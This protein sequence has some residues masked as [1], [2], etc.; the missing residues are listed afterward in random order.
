VQSL[1]GGKAPFGGPLVAGQISQAPELEARGLPGGHGN[2]DFGLHAALGV[3]YR[4]S[5]NFSLGFDGRFNRIAG[6]NGVFRT[7][8][9]RLGFHF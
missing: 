8:G 4:L 2:L 6:T 5:R 9:S 7:Y 1:F 3:E